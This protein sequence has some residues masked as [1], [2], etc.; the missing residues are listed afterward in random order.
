M[1]STFTLRL[2]HPDRA[3]AERL[4]G[5]CF[6]QLEILEAK[7]SRFR[8]DS[9]ISRINR[10]ASGERL[11]LSESTYRCLQLAMAAHA[12]TAGLFDVTLGQWT[13]KAD[14][15]EPVKG[16][17]QLVPDQPCIYCTQAGRQLD[18][19]GIGKGFA[20]DEMAKTLG[21]LGLESGLLSAGT[22][23][24]LAIGPETWSI[25]LQGDS[26]TLPRKLCRQAM[27]TSGIDM[28]GSHVIHPDM[29]RAPDYHF[30][31][32]WLLAETATLADAFSTACLLM[33]PD[34]LS[35]FSQVRPD[36]GIYAET[37]RNRISRIGRD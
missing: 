25:T 8:P 2:H 33:N 35:R 11:L 37:T 18:L 27:S 10:M 20:L 16:Q 26:E 28:Q 22:S 1:N 21:E 15:A 14:H 30:K 24:H 29:Y 3:T 19:G 6:V 13:G 34:E 32:I 5:A 36:L 7:L 17:L 4:A 23:T 9:E 31:R 12:A